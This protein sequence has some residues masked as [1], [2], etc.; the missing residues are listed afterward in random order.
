MAFW[1][2][3]MP[4]PLNNNNP[5]NNNNNN[6]NNNVIVGGAPL[7]PVPAVAPHANLLARLNRG[8][9]GG[10]ARGWRR[11]G[12]QQSD[13]STAREADEAGDALR[14]RVGE[15]V[16]DR[17]ARLKSNQHLAPHIP[18]TGP[19]N[20][21]RESRI[22]DE[23]EAEERSLLE[24]YVACLGKG[25]GDGVDGRSVCTVSESRWAESRKGRG[26]E[27]STFENAEARAYLT[28]RR[29]DLHAKQASLEAATRYIE[30]ATVKITLPP[31]PRWKSRF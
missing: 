10:A 24:R 30:E 7:P 27:R 11:V 14:V 2:A 18:R 6:N 26:P 16:D 15:E 5:N 21:D 29:E 13:T 19:L 31:A 25:V 8:L 23:R 4:W 28:A 22:I 20:L 3:M 12:R 9:R 1:N 17:F